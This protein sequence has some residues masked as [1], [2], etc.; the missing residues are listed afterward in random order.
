[1]RGEKTVDTLACILLRGEHRND[2]F[3]LRF[4]HPMT[5]S[6]DNDEKPL[7]PAQ[8]AIVRKLKRMSLVSTLVMI[9]G[10][11]VVFGVIAY[12]MST[13]SGSAPNWIDATVPLPAGA[14]VIS[15][16]ASDGRLV[17]T[18]EVGGI[19]EVRFFDLKTMES[20]GRVTFDAR[21]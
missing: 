7:D 15:T 11:L 9:G 21:K 10:F 16:T 5:Q 14:R 19:T 17:V 20:R 4:F 6:T 1:M 8:E 12:R 18:I 3:P 2:V 13:G